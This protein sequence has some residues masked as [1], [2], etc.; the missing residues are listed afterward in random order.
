M[1]QA[2]TEDVQPVEVV[3]G[4]ARY[5]RAPYSPP[6]VGALYCVRDKSQV[7]RVVQ[8]IDKSP[9]D[10]LIQVRSTLASRRSNEFHWRSIR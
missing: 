7:E 3:I 8:V 4:D 10:A 1:Q 6:E 2:A 5:R 9:N